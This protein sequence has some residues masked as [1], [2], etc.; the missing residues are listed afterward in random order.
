MPPLLL[1]IVDVLLYTVHMGVILINLFG[2]ISKKTRRIQL[3]SIIIT[4]FSWFI[5][6]FWY[7][8][9]YCFLT[10]WEWEIKAKLG[11]TDLPASFIHYLANTT[12]GF[13]INTDILDLITV[14][15]FLMAIILCLI[16]N[17]IDLR[18]IRIKEKSL[19]QNF[20]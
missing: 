12:L 6:G 16:T 13:N 8:W 19:N 14:I 1:N 9:G 4:S 20:L 10:D 2:W 3:I 11:E 5:V 7:G 15:T 18:R 17:Y